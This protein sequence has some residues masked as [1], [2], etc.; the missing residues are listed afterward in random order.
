MAKTSSNASTANGHDAIALLTADHKAAKA[1]FVAYARLA[2]DDD[3]R[4]EALV[5]RICDELTMHAQIEEELFYP[6]VRR[7]IDDDALLDEARV[8]HTT[9]KELIAQL[10]EMLPD[11]D[12][13]SAKVKVLAE[14]V[15]HHVKEEEDEMFAEV[16]KTD[17]DTAA[18]G[19]AM[20]ARKEVLK[21]QLGLLDEE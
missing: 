1:L 19:Q 15:E 4:K 5:L 8:E 3:D 21:Q 13:Y 20:A 2:E 18:L 10:M 6:A 7:A 11:D 12:L 14:Y 9:V 16:R 17:L